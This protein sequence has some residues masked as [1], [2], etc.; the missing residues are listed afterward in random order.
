MRWDRR[1]TKSSSYRDNYI[2]YRE[3]G[4]VTSVTSGGFELRRQTVQG[5]SYLECIDYPGPLPVTCTGYCSYSQGCPAGM[6]R[7]SVQ[8]YPTCRQVCS[9]NFS[10]VNLT[11]TAQAFERSGAVLVPSFG[12]TQTTQN[13]SLEVSFWEAVIPGTSTAIGDAV[14]LCGT[15]LTSGPNGTFVSGH[16]HTGTVPSD[17]Q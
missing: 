15:H 14:G 10:N 7:E 12:K 11:L 2:F 17:C 13:R 6:T 9:G 5:S 3:I 16:S 4:S 1:Q 8:G